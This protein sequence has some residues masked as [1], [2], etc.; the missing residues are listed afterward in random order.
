MMDPG[1]VGPNAFILFRVISAFVLFWIFTPPSKKIEKGDLKLLI[2]CSICGVAGNQLLF[3]NGLHLSSPLNAA[4]IMVCTP[5]LVLLIKMLG[6]SVLTTLQWI[7]CLLGFTGACYLILHQLGSSKNIS[8]GLGDIM[9]LL[10]ASLYA[11]YLIRVPELISKYGAFQTMRWTFGLAFIPVF[12]FGI[13]ESME[14]SFYSFNVYHWLA[15]AFVLIA[16]SFIAY[17]LNS[18]AL[19]HSE[20]ELV[21]NYIYLQPLLASII[22]ILLKKDV[23]EWQHF[24]SGSL[25]FTGLYLSSRK[26]NN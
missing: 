21:S 22:A 18:Y 10:N 12:I 15:F 17:A 13:G 16:T 3:F 8:S 25:I 19:Q 7:G 1:L 20:A 5:I 11:Y 9:V 4:L 26:K 2:I 14:V 23:L 24:L 6:G